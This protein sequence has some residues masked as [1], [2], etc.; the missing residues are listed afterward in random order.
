MDNHLDR[1]N[2]PGVVDNKPRWDDL[3]QAEMEQLVKEVNAIADDVVEMNVSVEN[4]VKHLR[5]SAAYLDQVWKDCKVASAVG[6][7]A[8]I[9]G[10]VLSVVGGVATFMTAGVAAPLMVAGVVFGAA[11]TCTNLGTSYIEASANSSR[12]RAADEAVEKASRAMNNVKE[13][14]RLL[15][16]GKSLSQLLFVAHLATRMLESPHFAVALI[17]DYISA[18]KAASV[19]A[20]YSLKVM[21]KAGSKAAS[22]AGKISDQIFQKGGSRAIGEAG[23]KAASKISN[24]AVEKG[25]R[26]VGEAATKEGA[27]A[28][29]KTAGY[30]IVG[31]NVVFLLVTAI[32]FSY[33]VRDIVVNR[34]SDAAQCLR[35][36]A[37]EMEVILHA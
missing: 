18:L 27:K 11:G 25:T 13:K 24:T 4:A 26:A 3:N 20:R 28:G 19:V 37:D 32:E 36:K 8:N 1:G 6:S 30:A 12:I 2:D 16:N 29:A 23:S 14:I 5:N 15:K 33:T 9:L 31:V 22:I 34:G 10:G 35:D 7:G 17:E 21:G